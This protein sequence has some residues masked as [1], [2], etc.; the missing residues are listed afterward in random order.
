MLTCCQLYCECKGGVGV[1]PLRVILPKYEPVWCTA[2]LIQNYLLRFDLCEN[3]LY[4]RTT[5]WDLA[6][7]IIMRSSFG[8]FHKPMHEKYQFLINV[9][10]N[11]SLGLLFLD[12]NGGF[13]ILFALRL[14][15][16]YTLLIK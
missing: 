12:F 3:Y 13:L 9:T 16:P 14:S 8:I 4:I 15:F 1:T 5:W 11:T 6:C 2:D 7:N 10:N